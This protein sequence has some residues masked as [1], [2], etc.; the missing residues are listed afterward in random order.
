[1][2]LEQEP[3]LDNNKTLI[4]IVKEGMQ[5]AVDA[6]EAYNAINDKF[7]LPEYYE[8]EKNGKFN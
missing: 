2:V 1:M 4:D 8:D 5:D 3:K 7:G 6:L